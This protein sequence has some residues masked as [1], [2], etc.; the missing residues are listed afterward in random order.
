[1]PSSGRSFLMVH[2]HA[3]IRKFYQFND[4]SCLEE[5]GLFNH[6]LQLP[7]IPRP[8]VIHQGLEG[9]GGGPWDIPSQ[10]FPELFQEMVHQQRDV[11]GPLPNPTSALQQLKCCNFKG[12]G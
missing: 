5:E 9:P 11:V 2:G 12:L 4:I 10:F 1:M 6:I 3:D 8:G 7:D